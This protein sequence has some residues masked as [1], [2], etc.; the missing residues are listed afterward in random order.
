MP[1][2]C[3]LVLIDCPPLLNV[4]CVNALAA[5]D[6]LLVP[7]M[8]SPAATERVGPMLA[9]IQSLRGTLNPTL[10]ILGVV[11]NRTA[12]ATGLGD[13]ERNLWN[14]V[15]D[16]AH[17]VWG[18]DVFMFETFV[19]QRT[20]VRNAEN[21]RRPLSE[22]DDAFQFFRQMA[23]ELCERLPQSSRPPLA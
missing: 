16:Q 7:V 14:A 13:V 15:R 4:S 17:E 8:P 3:D 12:K 5:A 21:D 20:E 2:R 6:Y 11:A 18:E 9:W 23:A 19:P 10:K 22:T 1:K